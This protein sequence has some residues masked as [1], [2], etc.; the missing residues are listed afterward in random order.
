MDKI[1]KHMR[2]PALAVNDIHRPMLQAIKEMLIQRASISVKTTLMKVKS[3]IGVQINEQA[4]QL[5]NAAELAELIAEGKPA[6]KD[7][8]KRT[9]T[10]SSGLRQRRLALLMVIVLLMVRLLLMVIVLM[11]TVLL[12]VINQY[13]CR[14]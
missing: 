8:S 2:D 11:V 14:T 13:A 1:A 4:D 7:V 6:N 9:L 5:A 3:H 10:A 12:M